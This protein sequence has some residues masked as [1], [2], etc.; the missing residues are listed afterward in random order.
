MDETIADPQLHLV[1]R[2][3]RSKAEVTAAQ[4]RLLIEI[5][6]CDRA[7][8]WRATGHKSM[9]FWLAAEL[10]INSWMANRYIK[11]SYALET[12]PHISDALRDGLLSVEQTVELA[13]FATPVD[14][15]R[16]ARW[17][18]DKAAR[19]IRNRAD[20]LEKR[21]LKEVIETERERF[22]DWSWTDDGSALWLEGKLPAAQGAVVTKT[23][24]RIADKLPEDAIQGLDPD[25][26]R[27]ARRADALHSL[28]SERVATDKD[29]DR[30]NVVIHADLTALAHN[31]GCCEIQ[32]GPSIN[33]ETARRLVCDGRLETVVYDGERIVGVGRRSR[34]VP[35]KY[36]RALWKRDRCC[37]FPGCPSTVFQAHH[38]KHWIWHGPTELP[39]LVL[40]CPRHH[41][42]LHE[43]HWRIVL[44]DDGTKTWISPGRSPPGVVWVRPAA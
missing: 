43:Y 9:S 29:I 27:Q 24:E 35:P 1:D 32:D 22:L 21:L 3:R 36:F 14:E 44:E 28:C 39:N 23:L 5:A 7:E 18:K 4:H 33:P 17:A 19:V 12:L 30:A 15:E 26:S 13:R 2:L 40:V 16:L 11:A 20:N 8:V 42:Y 38:I 10:G 6:E 34:S 41:T 31:D 37:A 25:H